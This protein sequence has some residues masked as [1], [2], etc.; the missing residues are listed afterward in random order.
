MKVSKKGQI[1]IPKEIRDELGLTPGEEVE[2]HQTDR[3]FVLRRAAAET[4][5]PNDVR[6]DDPLAED[7]DE[8]LSR[9]RGQ[10]E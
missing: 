7:P 2:F 1:T 3:G 4:F 6:A 5:P 8:I 10:L 9:T